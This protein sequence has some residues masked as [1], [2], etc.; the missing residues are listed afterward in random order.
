MTSA[1]TRYPGAQ[2]FS[3]DDFSRKIFF[4]RENVSMT[5]TDQVLANRMVVVYAKS[6]LGKTSLL[7]AGL[8]PRLREGGYL[9]LIVRVNDVQRGPLVSVLEGIRTEA[10]RQRVEY[11]MGTPDSLWTFFK[12][13]EFWRGDLLL[14]PVLILDQFEEL[15]T[16][17]SEQCRA[18]FLADLSYLV[19]RVRPPSS[20]QTDAN[21]GE[22]SPAVHII[23]SLR[24]DYLGFLEEAADHLPQILDHRFRLAPLSLAAATEA[25][26]EPAALDVSAL[27]TKPFSYDP[28]AVTT[29][30]NYLSQRG[31][32]TAG[33]AKQY[34]EPF[35]LQLV[36]QR[37]ER[38]V[39]ERQQQS[40]AH[41]T[42]T[43]TDIGGETV[44]RKTLT[45]FYV[46]AIHAL[47]KRSVRRAARRLC[48]EYLISPEGR[49]LSLE[50]NEIRRQ[51]KL[52]GET[53]R[54]LVANRLLRCESRSDSGY[55][56]LSHD[57]LVEP[58]LATRR[59]R[60]VLVGWLG[61]VAGAFFSLLMALM[62]VAMFFQAFEYEYASDQAARFA[63]IIG[64]STAVVGVFAA[65]VFSFGL[66]RAGFR[67]LR[68][69]RRRA[70][71]LLPTQTDSGSSGYQ[72]QKDPSG[73][74]QALKIML[75]IQLAVT[76]VSLF[77]DFGQMSL[78]VSGN[79]TTEAAEANDARQGM[80][81]LLYAGVFVATAVIFLIWIY[82]ANLN[83]RGFGAAD[84]RFTPGWSIGY[85]FI[86][87]LNLVR[88][89]QVMKEIWKV[90]ISPAD[91]K[92]QQGSPLLGWWWA[93][94]IMSG[95][96]GWLIFQMSM[97]VNSPSSLE[98]ATAVSIAA[99]LV[100]IPL[101][102]VAISLVSTIFAKQKQLTEN[103]G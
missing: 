34:V 22:S 86:P 98:A 25:M 45:D 54:Q 30:L 97:T 23:L 91:W 31:I 74:T 96:L 26:T 8:A 1:R 53:L 65:S 44:L 82:R 35:Q 102:F 57:T 93:L 19:R 80:I 46:A 18:S 52:S 72:F 48:E 20:V 88:P 41:L 37:V 43:M 7:N 47:P 90:S 4:G 89:Y 28:K 63:E 69:Y 12:T 85:Y 103:K 70:P 9:P 87:L 11:V 33:Q 62:G 79:I 66:V 5:L 27:E 15:I 68:R 95:F 76:V 61:L 58:V 59:K 55:Y 50:E 78:A 2:P 64:M 42:L 101:I 6:G 29:I 3:D 49:R 51:L 83:C 14:I 39:A 60:A 81:G 10:E 99:A 24:E 73:L 77:S 94:W 100:D 84:M 75:W 67:K 36:C 56:E 21:L 92:N 16:L 13:A 17:Q 38:I 32:K 40:P 71:P